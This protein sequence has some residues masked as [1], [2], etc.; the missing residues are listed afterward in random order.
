MPGTQKHDSRV[1]NH[2]C[3]QANTYGQ[4][5]P[6]VF[7]LHGGPGAPGHAAP[8]AQGLA[9]WFRVVEPWQRGSGSI[10]LTVAQHVADLRHLVDRMRTSRPAAIVGESWGAML[11]LAY[12]AV[13][14]AET[15]PLVLVGCGTFDTL[16]RDKL[17]ET[18]KVRMDKDLR[19]R[20]SS[21]DKTC[22]DPD[23][24]LRQYYSLTR[25][26]YQYD[27]ITAGPDLVETGGFDTQAHRET[28]QDMLRLQA[29]GSYP[30]AFA[31][32]RSPIL[33]LHGTYD[34]HPGRMILANLKTHL[35][36]IEY[37]EWQHCGH[38]PWIEKAV[39]ES[40]FT[41]LRD[42]LLRQTGGYTDSVSS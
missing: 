27:P 41:I 29:E 18:I 31:T 19:Q 5:G 40:F 30:A 37:Q 39:R 23:E 15:G 28:W 36:Q 26:L 34:P 4:D 38:T 25:S 13:Y 9:A 20:L 35:P 21:L 24:R 32:I 1:D 33:M 12:A 14:P 11:A 16:S 2:M 10:P 6:Q 3:L 22:S 17:Q 8:L 7:V 42:W